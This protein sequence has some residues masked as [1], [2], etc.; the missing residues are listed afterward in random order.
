MTHSEAIS[1]LGQDIHST[2]SLLCFLASA[3]TTPTNNCSLAE[4]YGLAVT[5]AGGV[6]VEEGREREQK[7]TSSRDGTSGSDIY[8]KQGKGTRGNIR[9]GGGSEGPE[10]ES[11]RALH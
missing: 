3:A 10:L 4:L 6:A 8:R 2:D 11:R 9:K 5:V 1:V 7:E